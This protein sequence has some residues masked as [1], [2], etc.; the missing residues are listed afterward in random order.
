MLLEQV[1]AWHTI[2][3]FLVVLAGLY[4]WYIKPT[5]D[6]RKD[7]E[8]W[9]ATTEYRLDHG[10]EAFQEIKR[11]MKDIKTSIHNLEKQFAAVA[12]ALAREIE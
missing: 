7:M 10:D 11:D 8:V 5:L 3:A 1:Q 6:W 9:R 12:P 4:R 2:V